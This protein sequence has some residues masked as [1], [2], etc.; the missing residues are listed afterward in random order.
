MGQY[1]VPVNLT[2]KEFID[3]HK[4]G[5]GLKLWEQLANHPST[6]TALLIL[7]SAMPEPRGGGDFNLDTDDKKYNTL[8]KRT[9]GRWAGDRIALVG[10]YAEDTDLPKAFKASKIYDKCRDEGHEEIRKTK[11]GKGKFLNETTISDKGKYVFWVTDKPPVFTDISD[12]VCKVIE[13]ELNGKY[14]DEGWRQFKYDKE[15]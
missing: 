12:D 2:K 5:C 15:N 6:G 8:A 10:D 7:C 13:H 4:L 11:T 3:P 1:W 14:I 9:I